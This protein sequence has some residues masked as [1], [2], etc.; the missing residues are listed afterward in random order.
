MEI[1]SKYQI[2]DEV[3]YS[4]STVKILNK[5]LNGTTLLWT[6]EVENRQNNFKAWV[7]EKDLFAQ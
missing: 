4:K 6:Y 3:V 7:K 2:G 1:K 5:T